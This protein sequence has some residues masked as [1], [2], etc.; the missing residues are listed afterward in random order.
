MAEKTKLDSSYTV[1][2]SMGMGTIRVIAYVVLVFLSLLC[3]IWFYLLF[4]NATRSHSEISSRVSFVP[5]KNLIKNF[6]KLN[7]STL[8]FPRGI[9][10]SAF[11]A[12]AA[13]I[14]TVYFSMMTAFAVH[15][16]N[17]KG[18]K[19][20]H[21]FILAIMMIPTQVTS[22][23]FY[24]LVVDTLN[25]KDSF[26]PLIVPSV[27]SPITYFYIVQYMKSNLPMS[28]IEAARIDG[29]K[30]ISILNR[31]VFPLMK[32]ALAVQLI[33][34][35]VASWNNYYMPAMILTSS[36]KRTL[37][38]LIFTLRSA[39]E[40]DKDFGF[41]YVAM[42]LSVLPVIVVYVFFARQIVGG[43]SVGGVK[44]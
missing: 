13:S 19:A 4:I 22:L 32:P 34:A 6:L 1:K 20:V 35:F 29:C 10:N 39:T 15:A 43:V 18:K 7:N 42:A 40:K 31:I 5:G 23:G 27:M 16:Y 37:P 25:L 36:K 44:E 14:L 33:F 2:K 38:I 41:Q 21:V 17:F 12:F 28:L 9:L 30:E 8:D 26:I 11:V 3:L 24:R